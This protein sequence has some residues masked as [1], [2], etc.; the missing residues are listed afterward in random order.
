ML[1]LIEQVSFSI[2]LRHMNIR[3]CAS[4]KEVKRKG[5]RDQ[6]LCLEMRR[7]YQKN[8]AIGEQKSQLDIF[9]Y[10]YLPAPS[11]PNPIFQLYWISSP[12]V[13]V[14]SILFAWNI[15]P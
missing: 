12:S 15:F 3:V 6:R 1:F 9:H 4:H 13:F 7:S 5:R 8:G 11:P 10:L 2:V 14:F